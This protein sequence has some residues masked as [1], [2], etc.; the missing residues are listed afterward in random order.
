MSL[1][2]QFKSAVLSLLLIISLT[3]LT[4]KA[5]TNWVEVNGQWRIQNADGS[6]TKGWY[7]DQSY[8][9][10]YFLDYKTGDMKTG[11]IAADSTHWYY[12]NTNG[13]M[14][15][16]LFKIQNDEFYFETNGH[17]AGSMR[18]GDFTTTDMRYVTNQS[19]KVIKKEPL[20]KEII[21]QPDGWFKENNQWY[22]IVDKHKLTGWYFIDNKEY[23]FLKSG[24]AAEGEIT[25][26]NQ[27]AV[28]S[29]GKLITRRYIKNQNYTPEELQK[30]KT[31][32]FKKVNTERV[33]NGLPELTL[34]TGDIANQSD[35][36]AKEIS[37]KFEHIRPDGRLLNSICSDVNATC[38]VGENIAY[39]YR[40]ANEVMRSWLASKAH[41]ANI[42]NKDYQ[43]MSIG[44]YEDKG[45]YYWVQDFFIDFKV[46]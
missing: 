20:V 38:I 15:T 37:T 32:I 31:T 1:L 28:F 43:S 16:G 18:T 30:I 3:P 7:K 10:W 2:K 27:I 12:L 33:E 24:V 39:G 29:K 19:G 5:A 44:I 25:F 35:I 14:Q 36:R 9:V 11:W 46:K 45:V 23:Y 8:N 41:K 17:Y 40:T 42:L 21:N 34:L 13:I 26:E 4:I 6:Y 22:Y